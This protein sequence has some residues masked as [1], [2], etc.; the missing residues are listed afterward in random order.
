M[1]FFSKPKQKG[2]TLVVSLIISFLVLGL[3]MTV[4][5]SVDRTL[6]QAQN[7]QRG[8]Q[9][10]YGAE[11]GLEA[12][13]FHHNVR[14]HG[15]DFGELT[16]T[17]FPTSLSIAHNATN[18][19][20]NWTIDGR[21]ESGGG[22][23]A[24]VSGLIHRDEYIQ[25][26]LY[27]DGAADPSEGV[28]GDGLDLDAEGFLLQLQ[29]PEFPTTYLTS[30]TTNS[31]DPLVGWGIIR[32]HNVEGLQTLIPVVEG[33]DPCGRNATFICDGDGASGQIS[34]S[35]WWSFGTRLNPGAITIQDS[36]PILGQVIPP[37]SDILFQSQTWPEFL[38]P[39]P[40]V[41]SNS[42]VLTLQGL[43]TFK[44]EAD[45]GGI[46]M[47]IEGV[48][49]LVRAGNM[50]GELPRPAYVVRAQVQQGDF[51]KTIET[52]ISEQSAS[53]VFNYVIFD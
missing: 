25:L 33:D 26:P 40:E 39:N 9:V 30:L 49:F 6:E 37:P 27:W 31:T 28:V 42:Y 53:G 21:A 16:Q 35:E 8:D 4:L 41:A 24:T 52:T 18:I 43:G 3:A 47:A 11:S 10:F 44:R 34:R 20:V 14:G 45:T 23:A 32:E 51:E 2:T 7:L 36:T 5:E 22:L 19:D 50:S 1:K 15:V 12:A 46:E 48:P 17:P 38:A 29:R 13:F